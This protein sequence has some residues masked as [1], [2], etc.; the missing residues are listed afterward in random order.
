MESL[1]IDWIVLCVRTSENQPLQQMK[2]SKTQPKLQMSNDSTSGAVSLGCSSQ[3][4]RRSHAC[5]VH[6]TD[7]ELCQLQHAE[8]STTALRDWVVRVPPS[9]HTRAGSL[10]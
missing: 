10:V 3:V 6:P 1:S 4:N 9:P 7:A 8:R 5:V 2:S